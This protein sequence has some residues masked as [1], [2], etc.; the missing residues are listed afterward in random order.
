MN[1]HQLIFI[2]FLIFPMTKMLMTLLFCVICKQRVNSSPTHSLSLSCL[3]SLFSLNSV[4][5]LSHLHLTISS[6]CILYL[7]LSLS[8]AIY[9]FIF[10]LNLSLFYL[11]LSL[12]FPSLSLSLVHF[13]FYFYH[14]FE[15][16]CFL[17]GAH[18]CISLSHL[19]RSTI[20][21]SL[22]LF[23]SLCTSLWILN[24]SFSL[25]LIL[26]FLPFLSNISFTF[27]YFISPSHLSHTLS[28]IGLSPTLF[29]FVTFTCNLWSSLIDTKS[30]NQISQSWISHCC[31]LS[32]LPLMSL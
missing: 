27:L 8:Y 15:I 5:P 22:F 29:I 28:F 17:S 3:C 19:S 20:T 25:A 21:R 13:H 6:L 31:C 2:H 1:Y 7:F 32:V 12:S 24:L 10:P 4:A 26:Y 14:F 11:Y 16:F 23:L 9:F 30:L 18:N